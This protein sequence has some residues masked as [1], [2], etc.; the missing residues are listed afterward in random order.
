M[1]TASGLDPGRFYTAVLE[2][3][4]GNDYY[5]EYAQPVGFSAKPSG[6]GV[7]ARPSNVM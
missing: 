5:G 2:P 3:Y 6:A 7:R 4:S 1:F